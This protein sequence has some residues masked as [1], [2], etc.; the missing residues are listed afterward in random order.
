[1]L[2]DN[3]HVRHFY[4]AMR[5]FDSDP[6]Y[7]TLEAV[8]EAA[9]AAIRAGSSDRILGSL[10]GLMS[11][12]RVIEIRR[13]ITAREQRTSGVKVK[14]TTVTATTT[15][16]HAVEGDFRIVCGQSGLY[17][18]GTLH[19]EIPTGGRLCKKCVRIL[20]RRGQES[21]S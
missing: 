5:V 19:S 11:D 2:Y 3:E 18:I 13:Q 20:D 14:W 8:T 9:Q 21:R 15:V 7:A 12:R 1:M 16:L 6:H 17:G 4:D 10:M